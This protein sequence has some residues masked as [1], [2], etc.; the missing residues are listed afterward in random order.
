MHRVSIAQS[1]K[2]KELDEHER[3]RNLMW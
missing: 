3:E 2:A 1:V